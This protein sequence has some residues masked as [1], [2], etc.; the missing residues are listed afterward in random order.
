[1][2]ASTTLSTSSTETS[3][4]IADLAPAEAVDVPIDGA[5]PEIAA[6]AQQ[7]EALLMSS[8]RPVPPTKIGQALG[9]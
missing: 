5:Q 1:M 6:L 2:E 9:L 4:A 7:V 3:A 8:P